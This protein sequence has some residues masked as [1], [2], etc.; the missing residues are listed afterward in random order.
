MKPNSRPHHPGILGK[1]VGTLI[2]AMTNGSID[3]ILANPRRAHGG[4]LCVCGDMDGITWRRKAPSG[5]RRQGLLRYRRA[6]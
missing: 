2:V 6:Q 5:Q 3:S 1:V 4:G